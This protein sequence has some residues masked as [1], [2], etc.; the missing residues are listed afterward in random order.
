VDETI[1]RAAEFLEVEPGD[2]LS[3]VVTEHPDGSA[4]LVGGFAWGRRFNRRVEGWRIT[5]S[6]SFCGLYTRS[7]DARIG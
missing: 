5:Y 1:K 7:L 3:C 4:T 6:E 2:I